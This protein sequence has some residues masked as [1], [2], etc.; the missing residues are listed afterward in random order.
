MRLN[1]YSNLIKIGEGSMAHVYQGMQ[2]SVKRRINLKLLVNGIISDDKARRHF[3][4]ESYIISRLNH[5]NIMPVIDRGISA[6]NVPYFIVESIEGEDLKTAIKERNFSHTEKLHLII[7]LLKALSYAHR[8]N[9]MHRDIRPA[10]ILID[11]NGGLKILD[12]GIAQFCDENR[13]SA[14]GKCISQGSYDYRS[15]EQWTSPHNASVQSDLYSVGVLMY[16]LFTGKIPSGQFAEPSEL[17]PAVSLELNRMILECLNTDPEKRPV[18]AILMKNE[19]LSLSEGRH[20]SEQEKSR[21][22]QGLSEAKS[23]FQLLDVLREDEFG[24]IYI[25]QQKAR[26]KLFIVKKKANTSPGYETSELMTSVHHENIVTTHK[27]LRNEEFF[28]LTQDYM[29]GGT[30][31]D[32]LSYQLSWIETLSIARQ[33][34]EGMSFAHSKEIVHGNLRPSNILFSETGQLKLTDFS[35][36]DSLTA[37][38]N[39]HCYSLEGEERSQAADFYAIGAILYQLFT[40]SLPKRKD[41]TCAVVRKFFAK[42]PRDIQE[43]ITNM[44]SSVP[45]NRNPECLQQA[46]AIMDEH[47]KGAPETAFIAK[48][49]RGKNR[50]TDIQ[51]AGSDQQTLESRRKKI[52]SIIGVDYASRMV[53]LFGIMIAM[54]SQYLFIFD[55]Q[56]KI[57]E[58][59]P[60][61]Y[62][63]VVDGYEGLMDVRDVRDGRILGI[64]AAYGLLHSQTGRSDATGT[65]PVKNRR[66]D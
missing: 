10:T 43:L 2:E 51:G 32:R 38:D 59:I 53:I 7:Q 28:V 42:L 57:Y 21:A 56:E 36:Q 31:Q 50:A 14:E 4:K 26:N 20:L 15:P 9:V 40:G 12:F 35:L 34:C 19:L 29:Q 60:I 24:A 62:A 16:E 11:V 27:I 54:Y 48:P 13:Q 18:S 1:G 58:S 23:S 33:I 3:E 61:V 25:Y 6:E 41:D 8:N 39:A 64:Y 46:I 55:G 22:E 17:N 49:L 45:E 63:D 52:A 5:T 44:L 30:L 37:V 65:S 66:P 47:A